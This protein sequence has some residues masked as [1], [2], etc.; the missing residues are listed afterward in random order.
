MLA[1]GVDRTRGAQFEQSA[2]D[3]RVSCDDRDVLDRIGLVAQIDHAQVGEPGN[4]QLGH[5]AHRHR[6]VERTR[7]HGARFDEHVDRY[8]VF[9]AQVDAT[10]LR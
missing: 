8:A 5:L 2:L 3:V 1:V 10:R 4:G 6:R 7:E 9:T